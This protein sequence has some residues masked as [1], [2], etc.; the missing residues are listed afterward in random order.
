[1]VYN[2]LSMEVA[3]GRM[4]AALDWTRRFYG[5]IKKKYGVEAQWM[6]PVDPAPGDGRKIVVITPYESLS[7]WAAHKE[8]CAKDPERNALLHEQEEKQ[9]FVPNSNTITVYVT[10]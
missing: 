5:Y 1:M 7:A 8:K 9:D 6:R 3:P 4:D 10:Q 2:I